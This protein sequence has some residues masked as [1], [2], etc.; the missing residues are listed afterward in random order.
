[1]PIKAIYE[2]KED[3]PADFESLYSE[4][5]GKWELTGVEGIKTEADIE[6]I[7]EGLRKEREEHAAAKAELA[8]ARKDLATA[9][10]ELKVYKDK[11]IDPNAEPEPP[12][13]EDLVKLARYERELA[14]ANKALSD[15][16]AELE[17]LQSTVTRGTIKD[18]LRQSAAKYIRE[19]ARDREIDILADMFELSD[20]KPLTKADL[21]RNSSLTAE[22]FLEIHVKENPFLAIPSNSGGAGGGTRRTHT[23][24]DGPMSAVDFLQSKGVK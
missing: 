7:H 20:G 10:D 17:A 11:G 19:D 12:K 6:R 13:H 21:E 4:R 1:M 24:A 8:T 22:E 16:V 14:D 15:K 23:N 18:Q 3:I 9:Q 5:D 2:K